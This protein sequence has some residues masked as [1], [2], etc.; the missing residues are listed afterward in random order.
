MYD[1]ERLVPCRIPASELLFSLM[2]GQR[3]ELLMA[4][5]F[6]YFTRPLGRVCHP[7]F[8]AAQKPP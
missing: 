8:T 6:W 7:A 4:F 2:S 3:M 5:L 1:S